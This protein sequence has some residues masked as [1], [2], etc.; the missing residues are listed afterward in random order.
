[1]SRVPHTGDIVVTPQKFENHLIRPLHIRGMASRVAIFKVVGTPRQR[2]MF[3]LVRVIFTD[4]TSKSASQP[5]PRRGIWQTFMVIGSGLA[6]CH[7]MNAH[8][9]GYVEFLYAFQDIQTYSTTIFSVQITMDLEATVYIFFSPQPLYQ[10]FS[11]REN[12]VN[13]KR[14]NRGTVLSSVSAV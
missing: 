11:V 4:K 9:D 2:I 14:A 13:H 5:Y 6:E 12:L 7:I 3:S 1:M 8:I 10:V